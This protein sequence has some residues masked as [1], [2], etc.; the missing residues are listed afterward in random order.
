MNGTDS[1]IV[2]PARR[3]LWRRL[4]TLAMFSHYNRLVLLVFAGNIA[5]LV[6]GLKTGQWWTTSGVALQTLSGLVVANLSMA[7]LIRQQYVINGLFWL[8]TRAPTS[9][10][11]A[12]RR[13]LASLP[14]CGRTVVARWQPL[15]GLR[16]CSAR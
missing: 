1:T 11:L 5:A 8:A 15:C 3:A 4:G 14:F 13:S 2:L 7:I 10:P 16:C 6:Y 12:I 9:W